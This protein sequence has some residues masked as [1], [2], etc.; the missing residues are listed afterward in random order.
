MTRAVSGGVA[1]EGHRTAPV[2]DSGHTAV[3]PA[4]EQEG[5]GPEVLEVSYQWF[6]PRFLDQQHRPPLEPAKMQTLGVGP[7]SWLYK[8]PGAL[9]TS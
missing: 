5:D 3:V 9:D 1:S 2:D 8:P 7:W 4:T 6:L